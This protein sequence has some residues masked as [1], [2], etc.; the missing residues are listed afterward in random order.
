MKLFGCSF[1]SLALPALLLA[2]VL[3][4]FPQ[5]DAPAPKLS[6]EQRE[7]FLKTAKILRTN[8]ASKGVTNT[9]RATLSDG[10][11]THDASIQTIDVERSRFESPAGLDL[12]F[13]DTY[14]HNIAAWR[15]GRMLG[16]GS[17]IPPSI[18]RKYRGKRGSF[19]WW[20][21]DVIMD[22][23]QRMAKKANPPDSDAYA[24]QTYIRMVFDQLIYNMDRNAGNILWDK[25]WHPWLIDHSRA[26]RTYSG[27]KEPA[28]VQRCDRVLFEKLR[29]LTK[30]SLEAE[31]KDYVRPEEIHALLERRDIIVAFFEKLGPASL[32]DWLPATDGAAPLK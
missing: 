3:S 29:G 8:W 10:K 4:A 16:M 7:Q 6:L 15:L 28:Q 23:A 20:V 26:F 21:D 19:T 13:R 31:L 11:I 5:V 1:V 30:E 32:Y 9:V 12:N 18:E 25:N 22:E 24:R 14:K 2:A 17:M 27:L